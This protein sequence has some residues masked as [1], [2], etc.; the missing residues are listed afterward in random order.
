MSE[1]RNLPWSNR[2][3]V[4]GL[5]H[6]RC[7]SLKPSLGSVG[8]DVVTPHTGITMYCV[9]GYADNGASGEVLTKDCEAAFRSDAREA[10]R[11]GGMDTKS[12]V[13]AG[14]EEGQTF[15][16]VVGGNEFIFGA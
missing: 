1:G 12:F 7:V 15:N 5:L 8:L 14:V 16:L 3:G 13:D 6:H 4:E 9:A 10:K 11:R 2:E